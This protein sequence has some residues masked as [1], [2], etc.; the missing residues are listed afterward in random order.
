MKN[1]L[2]KKQCELEFIKILLLYTG[3]GNFVHN[4]LKFVLKTKQIGTYPL[5]SV[6]YLY[7]IENI[8][9]GRKNQINFFIVCLK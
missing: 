7:L 3:L 8:I 1:A 4:R 2:I 9:Y 6:K 5:E